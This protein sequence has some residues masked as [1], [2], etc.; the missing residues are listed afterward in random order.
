MQHSVP[1]PHSAVSQNTDQ[2]CYRDLGPS[3]Q[4]FAGILIKS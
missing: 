4:N 2:V 3:L 1:L